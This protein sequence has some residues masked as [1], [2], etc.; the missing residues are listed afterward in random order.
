MDFGLDIDHLVH[1]LGAV[2]EPHPLDEPRHSPTRELDGGGSDT[3]GDRLDQPLMK[4]L[5][6]AVRGSGAGTGRWPQTSREAQPGKVFSRLPAVRV[7]CGPRH[8]SS[9]RASPATKY[10][11]HH[12]APASLNVVNGFHH[13]ADVEELSDAGLTG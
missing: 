5:R 4:R 13:G 3:G 11:W 8:R 10:A 6:R 12:Y 2:S 9:W 7:F 1:G